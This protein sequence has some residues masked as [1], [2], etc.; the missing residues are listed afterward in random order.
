MTSLGCNLN[1]A[2]CHIT[3]SKNQN[4]NNLQQKTI[5]ALNNGEFLENIKKSLQKISQSTGKITS[6]QF[7]GQEPTLTLHL[8]TEHLDE[9]FNTFPNWNALMFSTNGM[10]FGER[11]FDFLKAVDEYRNEDF[12]VNIQFSWDGDESTNNIRNGNSKQIKENIKKF[13]NLCNNYTFHHIHFSGNLHGVISLELIKKLNSPDKIINFYK[14]LDENANE[15][16]NFNRNNHVEFAP[17]VDLALENPVDASTFDGLSLAYFYKQSSLIRPTLFQNPNFITASSTLI[18]QY[19]MVHSFVDRF[20]DEKPLP[21]LFERMAQD[22]KLEQDF[23]N[24]LSQALWCGNGYGELKIM[25]NGQFITCQNSIY[26]TELEF[27]PTDNSIESSVK[28]TWVQKKYY[29]DPITA[30]ED[31]IRSFFHLY[32]VGK[33][34][35]FAFIWQQTFNL[36]LEMAKIGQIDSIYQDPK[37]TLEHSLFLTMYN[38]CMWNH[39]VKTGSMFLKSTGFIRLYCNG[40]LQDILEQK[41]NLLLQNHFNNCEKGEC[42]P[43]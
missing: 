15:L 40:F 12:F 6:I 25:Y 13:L 21:I 1:C 18:N 10:A 17:I 7:W 19:N 24:N 37:I 30:T 35:C 38:S 28:R 26:E 36:M 2:Y 14:N 41:S 16:F 42:C 34:S 4:S 29:L 5:Q 8:I 20:R 23:M 43:T 31:E 22:E 39:Y 11:I 9:W 32:K 3:Q 27:L 33:E